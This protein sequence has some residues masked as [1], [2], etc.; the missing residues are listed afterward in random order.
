MLRHLVAPDG[1]ALR[2]VQAL[3]ADGVVEAAADGLVHR[4]RGRVGYPHRGQPH[5]V[6]DG[7]HHALLGGLAAAEVEAEEAEAARAAAQELVRLVHDHHAVLR[8]LLAV[9]HLDAHHAGL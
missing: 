7:V 6:E 4:L 3:E 9:A 2:A 1:D 8:V 5:V